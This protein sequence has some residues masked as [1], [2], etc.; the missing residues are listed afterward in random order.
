[1][2]FWH[3]D[4]LSPYGILRAIIPCSPYMVSVRVSLKLGASWDFFSRRI[5][6]RPK[7]IVLIHSLS[8]RKQQRNG[9]NGTAK[10]LNCFFTW[11]E[12]Y[13]FVVFCWLAKFLPKGFVVSFFAWSADK[14]AAR[15]LEVRRRFP[16]SFFF[17]FTWN[18]EFLQ[19]FPCKFVRHK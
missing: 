17:L 14:K 11:E 13:S 5:E 6:R 8:F 3:F 1:M 18:V 16:V 9:L 4:W 10:S 12:K 7:Q 15:L 19:T 2:Q